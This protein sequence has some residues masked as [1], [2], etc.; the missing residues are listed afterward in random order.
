[1]PTATYGQKAEYIVVFENVAVVENIVVVGTCV[2]CVSV[3]SCIVVYWYYGALDVVAVEYG[4][5]DGNFVF[6]AKD[7][8]VLVSA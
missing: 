1:L 3:R 8:H 6:G 5:Y 4:L 7:Q 2:F